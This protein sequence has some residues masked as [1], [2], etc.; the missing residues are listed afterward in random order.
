MR[1]PDLRPAYLHAKVIIISRTANI[2]RNI[3]H[4]IFRRVPWDIL[5]CFM[6]Y[7]IMCREGDTVSVTDALFHHNRLASLCS[8]VKLRI[9]GNC[10]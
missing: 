8:L 4:A 6:S 1:T 2:S 10:L 3:F 9:W 5:H 7:V